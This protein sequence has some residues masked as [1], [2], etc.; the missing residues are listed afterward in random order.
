MAAELAV[1]MGPPAA[2]STRQPMSHTAPW[3]P[4]NGSKD[5]MTDANVKTANPRL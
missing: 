4:A 5:S 2:C 1:S 3:P